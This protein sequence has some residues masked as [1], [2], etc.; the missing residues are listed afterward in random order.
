MGAPSEVA[1]AL[2]PF[3]AA[4]GEEDFNRFD[5]ALCDARPERWPDRFLLEVF[6]AV[7]PV[8]LPFVLTAFPTVFL[9]AFADLAAGFRRGEVL[10][11][12]LRDFLDIRLPFVAFSGSIIGVLRVS[13]GEGESGQRLGRSEGPSL[14]GL[15]Y[16]YKEF[17][18]QPVRSLIEPHAG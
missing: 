5:A 12:F 13:F 16:G 15:G 10:G 3:D 11:D 14:T 17:D 4:G 18:A 2:R 9:A 7:A 8:F 6:A 1:A